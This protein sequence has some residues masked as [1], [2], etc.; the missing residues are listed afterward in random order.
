MGQ[1]S[2][3]GRRLHAVPLP[4]QEGGSKGF[5]HIADS[6][7]GGG[8]CQM[9]TFGAGRDAAGF[10]DMEKQSQ[11]DQIESHGES[12][13][14]PHFA[15]GEG[16]LREKPVVSIEERAHYARHDW[17]WPIAGSQRHRPGFFGYEGSSG[18]QRRGGGRF[19]AEFALYGK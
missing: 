17:H 16:K 12:V 7:A 1:C 3:C 6:G 9:R 11:V 14:G 5:F 19:L 8:Q 15:I 4:L 10:D 18:K 13:E 2:A